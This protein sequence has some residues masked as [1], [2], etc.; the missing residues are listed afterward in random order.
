LLVTLRSPAAGRRSLLVH[1]PDARD[2]RLLL[3]S[4]AHAPPPQGA[5]ANAAPFWQACSYER[6][7]CPHK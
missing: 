1:R 7:L 6:L 4:V 2:G 3:S 5:A